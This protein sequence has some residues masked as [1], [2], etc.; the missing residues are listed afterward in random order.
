[1][2]AINEDINTK[3]LLEVENLTVAFERRDGV[4]RAVEGMSYDVGEG[5]VVGLVG[6]S[7]SGKSVSVLSI[8][9]L[10]APNGRIES[11]KALLDGQ[12]LLELSEKELQAV[13]GRDVGMIFQNPMTSLNP[14]I[15]I[16]Q[17]I[18]EPLLWHQVCSRRE[19]QTRA[20][21]LLDM[22][23]IPS[24]RTRI[25]EYP[26]EFSG[27][28]R[29]RVMIAI[30]LACR[31]QLL[32]ADEPTTALDVTVQAQILDLLQTMG[33]ELGMAVIIITHD[34]AV[35]SEFCNRIVALYAGRIMEIGPARKLLDKPYHPYVVGL[36]QCTPDLGQRAAELQPIPG[37]PP[38]MLNPPSGCR[39]HP[40]CPR[41]MTIC[42]EEQPP[43]VAQEPGRWAACCTLDEGDS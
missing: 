27:G 21:E 33:K 4:V 30:A 19:A 35:T 40:R 15:R 1:M 3:S 31:P 16:G 2:T 18:M 8:L 13:R 37:S 39:F 5:E 14:T 17:Q 41:A 29:Q 7:G 38:D 32:I 26:F 36:L 24:P 12:D 28:M 23:G 6:E 43:L 25:N 22:V 10:L 9:R 20:V 42:R 34:L 11:G